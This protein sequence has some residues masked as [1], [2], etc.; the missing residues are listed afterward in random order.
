MIKRKAE[1]ILPSFSLRSVRKNCASPCN[2][3]TKHKQIVQTGATQSGPSEQLYAIHSKQK[4]SVKAKKKIYTD[5]Q[6]ISRDPHSKNSFSGN[7]AF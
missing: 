3:I 2:N 7:T 4:K 6:K 5:E 1:D